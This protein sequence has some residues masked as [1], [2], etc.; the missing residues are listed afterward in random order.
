MIEERVT[1]LHGAGGE[2]MGRLLAEHVLPR[3]AHRSP[4]RIGLSAL[5]DGATVAVPRG[6]ELVVTTDSHVVMCATAPDGNSSSAENVVSTR[7]PGLVCA[8]ANAR[9]GSAPSTNRAAYT[10]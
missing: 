9:T 1:S 6:S 7:C 2:V 3:F 10:A 4:G 8:N 5:D